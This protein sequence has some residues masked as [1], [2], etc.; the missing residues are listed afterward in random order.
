MFLA[1]KFSIFTNIL[2]FRFLIFHFPP[3]FSAL[4]IFAER[5]R[6]D[7]ENFIRPEAHLA[8]RLIQL[9]TAADLDLWSVCYTTAEDVLALGLH[10]LVQRSL[11]DKDPTLQKH[12]GVLLQQTAVFYAKLAAVG[13][14]A[15]CHLLVCIRYKPHIVGYASLVSCAPFTRLPDYVTLL[16][17]RC[18]SSQFILLFLSVSKLPFN[19]NSVANTLRL[20]IMSVLL[21]FLQIFRVAHQP[22]FHA[23]AVL[24][25]LFHTRQ[26][27]KM[28]SQA[29][30]CQLCDIGTLAVLSVPI[31]SKP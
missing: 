1:A 11:N 13:L 14:S 3:F 26:H 19:D 20:A 7:F 6:P 24:R 8:T 10:E 9:E 21:F 23:S 29:E 18:C 31:R 28:A 22:V 12:R 2:S 5:G 17:A 4:H 27:K 16:M 30:L 15:Y 25:N